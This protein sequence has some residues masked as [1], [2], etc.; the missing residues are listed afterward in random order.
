MRV[1]RVFLKNSANWLDLPLAD[2]QGMDDIRASM[3]VEGCLCTPNWMVRADAWT[4]IVII[5]N[6]QL[7]AASPPGQKGGY[8]VPFSVVKPGPQAS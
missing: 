6:G 5:D 1:A 8:T 7:A 2:N 3:N 4:W